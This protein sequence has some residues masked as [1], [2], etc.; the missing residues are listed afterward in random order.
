MDLEVSGM[1]ENEC[2]RGVDEISGSPDSSIES[3]SDSEVDKLI[4]LQTRK[5][6]LMKAKDLLIQKKLDLLENIRRLKERLATHERQKLQLEAK[7]K[8]EFFLHQN[9]HETSKLSA[10]DQASNFVIENLN[11]FVSSEWSSRRKIIGKLYPFIS[12]SNY[13][14]KR[15]FENGVRSHSIQ[16]ILDGYGMPL[17]AISVEVLNETVTDLVISNWNSVSSLLHLISPTYKEV[18][19]HFYVRLHKLDMLFYSYHCLSRIQHQKISV[20]WKILEQYP[21]LVSHMSGF[22]KVNLSCIK[23]IMC[24]SYIEMVI[25][26]SKKEF[27]IRLE[28]VPILRDHDFGELESDIRFLIFTPKRQ[29]ISNAE[30]V[31]LSLVRDYG[32][33]KAFSLMLF[34]LFEIDAA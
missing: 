1:N 20:F 24:Y 22:S 16:F 8:L 3:A 9:D 12:I 21:E 32:V 25:E 19:E 17:L 28:W 5:S 31:F 2:Q 23:S 6:D 30:K 33:Y 7:K 27:L 10:P 26:R 13:A 14:S 15:K 34:N 29:I 4:G 18:L 11:I